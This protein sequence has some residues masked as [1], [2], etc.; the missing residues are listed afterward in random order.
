MV[1]SIKIMGS[2]VTEQQYGVNKDSTRVSANTTYSTCWTRRSRPP[3][4]ATP[5]VIDSPNSCPKEANSYRSPW[6]PTSP[7]QF[8]IPRE[9][10]R[11]G[12]NVLALLPPS[13][14]SFS[15]QLTAELWSFSHPHTHTHL[16]LTVYLLHSTKT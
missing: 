3:P 9:G 12:R 4:D 10:C 13:L 14:L 16:N 15:S 6:R 7:L 5:L 2:I 1:E 8:A 11:L